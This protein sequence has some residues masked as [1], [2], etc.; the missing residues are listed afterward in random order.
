MTTFS[1][2]VVEINCPED[3]KSGILIAIEVWGSIEMLCCLI[4]LGAF[5]SA[6]QIIS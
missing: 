5:V 1:Y 2:M 3:P 6:S 4:C